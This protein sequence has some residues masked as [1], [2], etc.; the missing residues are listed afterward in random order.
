MP[1]S[2]TSSVL[3]DPTATAASRSDLI[4]AVPTPFL[5]DG[6][7]DVPGTKRLFTAL[8]VRDVDGAFVAGTTGEFTTLED[9]ERLAVLEAGLEAFGAERAYLHVGAAHTRHAVKLTRA[10]VALGARKLAA[11]TPYYFPAPLDAVVDYF[12][13]VV[14]AAEGAAVYAYL[15][16]ARTWTVFPHD[17]LGRLADVG[18]TG[19]K[20]SGESDESVSAYLANAPAG[21]EVLSG[22]DIAYGEL[23][24]AGGQGI[25]SGV[26]SVFPQ[27]FLNLRGALRAGDA[28]GVRAAKEDVAR[29]VGLVRAGSLTHLKAG[30]ELQGLPA[31]PVRAGVEPISD[32]DRAAIARELERWNK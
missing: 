19:V 25:I 30:L 24:A 32:D 21:F 10:A 18:V 27:P 4:T 22:N 15:F 3:T 16:T 12:R 23:V 5:A 20:I 8:A 17:A 6:S 28:D 2:E 11:I 13:Q 29:A 7:L 1:S 9:D 14:D 31:G 26:S